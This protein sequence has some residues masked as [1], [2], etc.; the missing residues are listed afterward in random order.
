[1]SKLSKLKKV[2]L[3]GKIK[4]LS[5]TPKSGIKSLS[6]NVLKMSETNT[7]LSF[8]KLNRN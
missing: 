8:D 6:W 3:A 2:G 4:L 1:M 5:V 7:N